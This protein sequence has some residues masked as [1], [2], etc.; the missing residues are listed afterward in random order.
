MLKR[1]IVQRYKYFFREAMVQKNKYRYYYVYKLLQKEVDLLDFKGV[2][3]TLFG[4]IVFSV[5]NKGYKL[6]K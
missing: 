2:L 1:F 6:L 4:L 5:F 3:K